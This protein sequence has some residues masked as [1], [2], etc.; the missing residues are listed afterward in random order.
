MYLRFIK[1]ANLLVPYDD[2]TRG[3]VS[4]PCSGQVSSLISAAPFLSAN[5]LRF[6]DSQSWIVGV[7][8]SPDSVAKILSVATKNSAYPASRS[9]R[10]AWW[11]GKRATSIRL[12]GYDVPR[13]NGLRTFKAI[14]NPLHKTTPC[15]AATLVSRCR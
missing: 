9:I 10:C 2:M 12:S 13:N 15:D 4:I 5:N 7:P 1:R 14:I 8:S 3:F 11:R 6:T